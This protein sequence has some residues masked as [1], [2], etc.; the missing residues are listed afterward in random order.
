MNNRREE[1]VL[2]GVLLIG[3]AILLITG[4]WWPGIMFVVGIAML[5][6]TRAQGRPWMSDLPALA[7]LAIGALLALLSLIGAI[8]SWKVIGPVVLIAIGLWILFGRN[9]RWNGSLGNYGK[10]KNDDTV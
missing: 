3:L 8:L 1:G 10:R 6:R 7:V 4:W 9:G 5:A 2:G